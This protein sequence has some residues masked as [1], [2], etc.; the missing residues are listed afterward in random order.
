MALP[1]FLYAKRL[2]R[3]KREFMLKSVSNA[4]R[5]LEYLVEH[6]E[7]GVSEMGRDIGLSPGTVYR[8]VS[9]LVD[10]G[11][12]DQNIDNRRYIPGPRILHLANVMRNRVEFLDVGRAH[13]ERLTDR[14]NETVNFA[15][16]RNDEV[17]YVDR[18]VSNQPLAV[19]VRIG[20]HVP[21]FCTALGKVL[22]AFSSDEVRESYFA[23]LSEFPDDGHFK[24]TESQLRTELARIVAQGYAED[25][26]EFSP[27]ISCVAT[28][29]LN[30]KGRAI[31]AVS[32]S[33][34]A[35]RF[36]ARKDAL[37]PMIEITGKE[38]TLLVTELGDDNPR[39]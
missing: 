13:L 21:V 32:V 33:G 38:L 12:A 6:G 35:T 11:F 9:T 29:V 22:L 19:E 14:A 24:P 27:D 37:I 34:P 28:P 1:S 4:L 25:K 39:L 36:A 20:S 2:R 23:R 5:V 30:S 31:A 18:V 17:V 26:G 7:G 15:V 8:L 16:M 3:E 10:A